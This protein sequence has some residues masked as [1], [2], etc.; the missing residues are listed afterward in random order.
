MS[1]IYYVVNGKKFNNEFLAQY[2]AYT[3]KTDVQFYCND[4]EYD[5][6]NWLYEPSESMEQ[7]MDRHAISLRL[8]YDKLILNWS[9]GTDSHTIYNVFKRN[10]IHIDE[11]CVKY[12]DGERGFFPKKNADWL[13]ENHWDKTTKITCVYEQ[14]SSR[15]EVTIGD[16]EWVYDNAGNFKRFGASGVDAGDIHVIGDRYSSTKWCIITGFEKPFLYK[17]NDDY[18]STIPDN[19]IRATIGHDNLECFFLEPSIHLKQCHMLKSYLKQNP[20]LDPR[21]PF[22]YRNSFGKDH[23]YVVSRAIGRHD[24]LFYGVSALQ[25]EDNKDRIHSTI[26][27]D[28]IKLVDF[29][30]SDVFLNE[31]LKDGD[32]RALDYVKGFLNMR[33]DSG[34][35]RYLNENCFKTPNAVLTSKPIFARSY[36]IGS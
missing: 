4:D 21:D 2:E 1:S 3:S 34:F 12:S 8:K 28:S 20:H 31:K 25:K 15:R 5:K 17:M 29:T 16:D 19:S 23:Y 24:E 36:N 7:L 27:T 22:G 30:T 35:W 6:L 9:G 32:K 13:V 33:S 10:N 26:I 14:E 11:I 18:Y